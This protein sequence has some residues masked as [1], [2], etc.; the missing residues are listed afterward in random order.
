MAKMLPIGMAER[1]V[2]MNAAL[3]SMQRMR[4]MK[5]LGSAEH[6][7]IG[8]SDVAETLGMAQ[9]TATKHLQILHDAGFVT[10]KKVGT[11]VYY[12]D[13][14]DAL[15]D[16]RRI[17]DCAFIAQK[18]PCINDWDCENCPDAASCNTGIEWWNRD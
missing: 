13:N 17:I 7:T 11:T 8:V 5:V 15:A 1:A 6:G 12:S 10:R 3:A 4:I 18:T 14:P 9:S 2:A 16:Y